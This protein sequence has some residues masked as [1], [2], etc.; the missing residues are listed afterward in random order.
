MGGS[1]SY[2]YIFLGNKENSYNGGGCNVTVSKTVVDGSINFEVVTHSINYNE[3]DG[4]Y[5]DVY[6]YDSKETY[7][8]SS[9]IFAYCSPSTDGL[10]ANKVKAYYSVLAPNVPLVISFETKLNTY[11]CSIDKLLS[12]RWNWASNITEYSSTEVTVLLEEQFKKLLLNRKIRFRSEEVNKDIMA[13]RQELGD[14]KNFRFIFLPKDNEP[15]LGSDYLFSIDF[16]DNKPKLPGDNVA[17]A[18]EFCSRAKKKG[19]HQDHPPPKTE[20]K[21]QID[22]YFLRPFNGQLYDGIMVYLSREEREPPKTLCAEGEYNK[23]MAILLEFYDSSEEKKYLKRKD[24]EGYWW[25]EEPIEYKDDE[26]LRTQL[27]EIGKAANANDVNTVLLDKMQ[28]YKGVNEVK[29]DIKKG[30]NKYTYTFEKS[31]KPV[32]L[33]ERKERTIGQFDTIKTQKIDVYYLKAKDQEDKEPFLIVFFSGDRVPKPM[34]AYHFANEYNFKGWKEFEFDFRKSEQEKDQHDQERELKT[35]LLE[36]VQKIDDYVKC[37]PDMDLLRWYAYTILTDKEIPPPKP[38]D[39]QTPQ[40][41][42]E[43]VPRKPP[44]P[45]PLALIIGGTVGG[46]VFVVSSAVGYGVYWYNTTIKLLT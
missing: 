32:F 27:G 34:N 46:V 15:E 45:P 9:Y 33:F 20:H 44:E 14:K 23:G 31:N 1:Q 40:R 29:P 37:I 30:Y 12:A 4:R 21:N 25:A 39:E 11:N 17:K 42:D 16:I 8:K 7:Y 6:I 13:N 2:L 43:F 5:F 28:P 3:A 10:V 38:K 18:D 41:P 35:K 36:K 24:K 19:F 26:T 22:E